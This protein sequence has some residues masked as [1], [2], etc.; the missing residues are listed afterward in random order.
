MPKIL[1]ID[2]DQIMR[3]FLKRGLR[4]SYATIETGNP[5]E[6]LA[7]TLEEKPDAILV[8]LLMP[9]FS[10]FELCHTIHSL[11][12]TS[13]IPIFVVSGEA[14]D[15][16]R[17]DLE[18][19]GAKGYFQKPINFTELKRALDTE[20]NKK[21]Q[22]RRASVRVRMRVP[23]KLKGRDLQGNFFEELT[24]T[25]NVSASGFLCQTNRPLWEGA[26]VEVF[27]PR[28][29][30]RYAGL[31]QVVR[32][33]SQTAALHHYGFRFKDVTTEW[34]LQPAACSESERRKVSGISSI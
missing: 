1:I 14:N 11:S 16:C 5:Q 23:L 7:L 10:G 18:K 15:K 4:D 8:D 34:V 27:L 33:E 30:E 20:I 21:P 12:Y 2:D 19:L 22:E 28:E 25:E 3:G 13:T 29:E 17:Q 26:T 24:E 32:Q 31:A 6:A 9:N